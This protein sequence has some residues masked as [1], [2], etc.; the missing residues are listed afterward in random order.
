MTPTRAEILTGLLVLATLG[1]G[2]VFLMLLG[3]G[4]LFSS[5]V[6]FHAFLP[7]SADLRPGTPVHFE[8]QRVGRLD[9]VAWAADRRAYR[10]TVRVPPETPVR[11]DSRVQLR[12]VKLLGSQFVEITAGSPDAARA[13]PE[14][15]LAAVPFKALVEGVDRLTEELG[16]VLRELQA[17]LADLRRLFRADG[18]VGDLEATMVSARS[19]AGKLDAGAG[20]LRAL[21]GEGEGGLG[22]AARTLNHWLDANAGRLG[23]AVG[24]LQDAAAS[25]RRLAADAEAPLRD[26]SVGAR[27]LVGQLDHTAREL[28]GAVRRLE[29]ALADVAG[30]AGGTIDQAARLL[31]DNEADLRAVLLA[32]RAASENLARAAAK[33]ADR[34]STL[35]FD[36][37]DETSRAA[38]ERRDFERQLRERGRADRYGKD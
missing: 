16:P 9:G 38:R 24:D 30:R 8:G 26:A 34:P 10:L 25:L 31:R 35:L 14:A 1:V 28:D 12:A 13:A 21:L 20:D 11:V 19:A 32:A 22:A 17:T 7:N 36:A 15:E 3:H 33:V 27:E 6:R 5:G 2:V 4:T 37:E 18:A 23:T 29:G